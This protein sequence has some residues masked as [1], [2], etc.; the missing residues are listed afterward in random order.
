MNSHGTAGRLALVLDHD[1]AR[2]FWFKGAEPEAVVLKRSNKHNDHRDGH[3]DNYRPWFE[4]V[5]TAAVGARD[6]LLLGGGKAKIEFRHHLE[7]HH[8]NVATHVFETESVD[9]PTDGQV[10]AQAKKAFSL[11]DSGKLLHAE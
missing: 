7:K 1:T 5:A 4:E 6:I 3:H 11:K 2:L 8:P 9:H 10:I